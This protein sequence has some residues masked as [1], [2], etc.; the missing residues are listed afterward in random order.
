MAIF[1]EIIVTFKEN[2]FFLQYKK[3]IDKNDHNLQNF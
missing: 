1:D 2:N 3:M